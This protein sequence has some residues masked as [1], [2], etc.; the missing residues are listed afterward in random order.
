MLVGI[1]ETTCLLSAIVIIF[2]DLIL[3]FIFF[4]LN[5]MYYNYT[6]N[7]NILPIIISQELNN[8]YNL[9]NDSHFYE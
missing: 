2:F 1:S 5:L 6:S 9:N 3:S 7:F 8:K 4:E